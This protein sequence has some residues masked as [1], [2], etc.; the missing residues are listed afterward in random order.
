MNAWVLTFPDKSFERNA[1]GAI[2]LY[3]DVNDARKR[4]ENM[5]NKHVHV[6]PARVVLKMTPLRERRRRAINRRFEAF[7]DNE[8]ASSS[9]RWKILNKLKADIRRWGFD[10][11][12]SLCERTPRS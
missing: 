5:P 9:T 4:A 11:P 12:G 3:E 1:E 8:K 7:F 6:V 2:V 10:Y